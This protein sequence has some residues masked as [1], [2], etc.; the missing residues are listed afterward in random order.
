MRMDVVTT[1]LCRPELLDLTYRSFFSRM[2]GLPDLR[3]IINI[4]PLGYGDAQ[5][6]V[7]VARQ[8]SD[9]V[10][11]R[12]PP[13]PSFVDA[14]RWCYNQVESDVVFHLEDDWFLNRAI[15]C[16]DMMRQLEE[17]KSDQL[18][19]LMKR[20]RDV[21][22]IKYSFRPHLAISAR[23]IEAVRT[24]PLDCTNPE[25]GFINH[26]LN[27]TS[28]DFIEGGARLVSDM[29]RKWAK[30]NGLKK[31]DNSKT[32]FENRHNSFWGSVEYRLFLT[33]WRFR[34][35]QDV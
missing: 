16:N 25:K 19:L 23:V 1:G 26:Q 7:Q 14:V 5:T 31:S 9:Q 6:C 12:N 4:D 28:L 32:W 2:Q 3:I 27:L 13:E 24:L 30:G 18:V 8:Y 22:T 35:W 21:S 11:W 34:M 17:G 20:P 33:Y 10:I 29:G 15:N